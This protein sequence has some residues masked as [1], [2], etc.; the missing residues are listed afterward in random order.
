MS[1]QQMIRAFFF[2]A[3]WILIAYYLSHVIVFGNLSPE[4]RSTIARTIIMFLGF[5]GTMLGEALRRRV[6][7]DRSS[8][9]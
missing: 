4:T 6:R 9:K 1:T 5:T 2:S 8:V 3:A 7:A